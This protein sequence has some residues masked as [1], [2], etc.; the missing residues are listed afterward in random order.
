MSLSG[1]PACRHQIMGL[2]ILH[3]YMSQFLIS[4]LYICIFFT[5]QQVQGY[6]VFNELNPASF[7][8]LCHHT[9]LLNT[10]S[11]SHRH[12]DAL[13]HLQR[14][15][16]THEHTDRCTHTQTHA[17]ALAILKSFLVFQIN[18]LFLAFDMSLQMLFP[19][20]TLFRD[21]CLPLLNLAD[22]IL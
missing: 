19:L 21:T 12:T 4:N 16:H 6:W 20:L 17:Y 7:S 11:H 22:L 5:Y 1:P 10:N 15:L 13:I 9:S 8:R 18:M 14:Y 2:L 3:N